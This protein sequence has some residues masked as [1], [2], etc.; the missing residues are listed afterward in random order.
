M[1]KSIIGSVFI[2]IE[3]HIRRLDLSQYFFAEVHHF[4]EISRIILIL[5]EA[6]FIIFLVI[7]FICITLKCKSMNDICLKLMI[8]IFPEKVH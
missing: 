4:A 8:E 2:A 3:R 5:S 1:H 6:E 7:R